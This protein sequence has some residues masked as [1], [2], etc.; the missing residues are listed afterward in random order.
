M[1]GRIVCWEIFLTVPDGWRRRLDDPR[2]WWLIILIGL[3]LR[4]IGAFIS[5]LSV[6]THVHATYVIN[7]LGSG[8]IALDWGPNRNPWNP[9]ASNPGAPGADIGATYALWHAWIGIWIF[10]FGRSQTS[11]HV[12]GFVLSLVMM[13]VVYRLTKQ[14]F[15]S[16]VALR[17]TAF[18]AIQPALVAGSTMA[19]N[20]DIMVMLMA[21]AT[22][23]LLTGLKQLDAR[24]WPVGW[25]YG[26]VAL[27]CFGA[28]KGASMDLV[29]AVAAAG[30]FWVLLVHTPQLRLGVR[31]RAA[32][33]RSVSFILAVMCGLMLMEAVLNPS[34]GWSMAWS[35]RHPER[36]IPAVALCTLVFVG[37][38]GAVGMFALPWMSMV[39]RRLHL[40][41][42]TERQLHLLMIVALPLGFIVLMNASF[43]AYEGSIY[44]WGVVKTAAVYMHNGRYLTVLLV[45]LHWF[46][47]DVERDMIQS[48]Q[49]TVVTAPLQQR[50]LPSNNLV[51]VGT[52]A[53]LLMLM[54]PA[55]TAL[56]VGM[57]F[58]PDAEQEHVADALGDIIEPEEDFLVVTRTYASMSRLYLYHMGVD[59]DNTANIT[60]HWRS[61]D[62]AWDHELL[63]FHQSEHAGNLT[64][65]D[66][67][68]L[69][70]EVSAEGPEGWLLL[71]LELPDGWRIYTSPA[72]TSST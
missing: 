32:P 13:L 8:D 19:M 36:F 57:T 60:G 17:V 63:G 10:S 9:L 30:A 14:H 56:G 72:R 38:W 34:P 68:V 23:G 51:H 70:S 6:D 47:A 54:V 1:H 22:H 52:L 41:P 35:V 62:T 27:V 44:G 59:P 42:V 24:Q 25:S 28:T 45:P 48:K 53:T 50:M 65:V 69:G 31:M 29:L 2:T 11:L 58:H 49:V 37:L 15:G 61:M 3:G 20:E 12:A 7:F 66:L 43:W 18:A 67:L 33:L 16:H 5:P 71:D 4:G 26:A 39:R 40:G 46:F 55:S 64:G 21:L